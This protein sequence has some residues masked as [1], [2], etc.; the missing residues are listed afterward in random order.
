MSDDNW[1]SVVFTNSVSYGENSI[2]KTEQILAF[3][4]FLFYKS[5]LYNI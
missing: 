2:H 1:D 3:G 5:I 4:D